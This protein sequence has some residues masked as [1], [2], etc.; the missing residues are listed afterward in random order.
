VHFGTNVATIARLIR[1][2]GGPPYSFTVHGPT[3]FDAAIGFDLAG[4]IREARFVVA[5]TDYC[6]AQLRRWVATDSWDKIGVVRCTV[7][8]DFFDAEVPL[9]PSSHTFVCVGRLVPQKGQLV[10]VQAL[11]ELARKRIDAKVVFVGD[12]E[13]RSVIE[14]QA[15]KLGV[16]NRV[17]ITGFLSE[18]EV[19][20]CM[21]LSRAV[22]MPS[23]AEGLPMVLMEAFA[24]GRPVV[25]TYV[26]GIPELV[27]PG[28][29]G[30][31]VP[32]GNAVELAKALEAVL[33]TPTAELA[34]MAEKGRALTYERHRT[35]TEGGRLE[36]LI[37]EAVARERSAKRG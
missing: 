18:S 24:V 10:L 32:A 22:V 25:S 36:S 35:V 27:R 8:G 3:E 14:T 33:D 21:A 17:E 34:A 1:R 5:I 30:W 12:G 19:R 15:T 37:V 6:S 2:L 23:F 11:A 31:L 28:E 9:N 29:N 16:A 4:K 20:K 26:A 13:L 7:G